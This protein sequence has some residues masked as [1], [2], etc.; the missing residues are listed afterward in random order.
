[1]PFGLNLMLIHAIVNHPTSHRTLSPCNRCERCT[2]GDYVYLTIT[3]H[4]DASSSAKVT[5]AIKPPRNVQ[6]ADVYVP[7]S[8]VVAE[9]RSACEQ[10]FTSAKAQADFLVQA[11]SHFLVSAR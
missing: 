2:Q 1:M 11:L 5:R 10:K 3:A 4:L 6:T 7:S 8:G 9:P